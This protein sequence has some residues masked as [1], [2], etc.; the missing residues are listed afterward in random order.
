MKRRLNIERAAMLMITLGVMAVIFL[1]SA[2]PGTGSYALSEQITHQVQS[3]TAQSLL[4]SFFSA[5]FHANLRK[6]AHV[7]VFFA[8]GVSMTVTVHLF[9]GVGRSNLP[10]L[11]Q[12]GF[13]SGGLCTA[14]AAL[15]ELHQLFVPG[16]SGSPR[17][18]GIDALGFVPGI[19]IVCLFLAIKHRRKKRSS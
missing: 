11:W 1:L 16:R 18:V 15:D 12:Q 3:S 14:Y 17:D 10:T 5:D 7:Y 19:V 9:W 6:W 2:Q 4:P 13:L 8:L